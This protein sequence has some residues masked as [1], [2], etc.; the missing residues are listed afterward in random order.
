MIALVLAGALLT[1]QVG[2]MLHDYRHRGEQPGPLEVTSPL[3]RPLYGLPP[4]AAVDA[5][6]AKLAAGPASGAGN[7]ALVLALSKAEAARREYREAIGV[8]TAALKVSPT[9]ADLLLERGHRELGLRQF[10]AAERDLEQARAVAPG[11]L[12]VHYHLALAHYFLREFGPAADEFKAARDLAKN[13]DSLIDCT[14][15]L[16]VSLRRAGRDAEAAKALERITPEVHN[17]EPHLYFYLRLLRFYQGRLTLE[18]VM[19]PAP[20]GPEDSEG[21]LSFDT[22]SYGVGNWLLYNGK[23]EQ[24]LGLFRN[25]I[26]GEAWNA[27]GFIGSENE[28]R[29]R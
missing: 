27:W 10:K 26:K 29:P 21:E 24:A 14:N 9:N 13:D 3:G 8:D 18:Q 6:K 5:A 1:G 28:L 25:V 17:T 15:W 20:K 2:E 4:D 7:V 23:Q 22:V 16:Y 12:D 19:P 11:M